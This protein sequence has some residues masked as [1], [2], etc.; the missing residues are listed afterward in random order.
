MLNSVN[1]MG[2]LVADPEL[3]QTQTGTPVCSFRIAVDRN[4]SNANNQRET[5]FI[6][7]VA[8][9]KTAEFVTQYFGKGAMIIVQGSIQTRNYEDKNGNKRTAVEVVASNVLF[10][11][12]KAAAQANSAPQ[13]AP[14]PAQQQ[15]G[16]Q[17]YGQPQSPPQPAPAPYGAPQQQYAALPQQGY[18]QP[19]AY[20]VQ[21]QYAPPPVQQ[22]PPPQGAP[23]PYAPPTQP[24]AGYA[25]TN[26]PSYDEFGDSGDLPF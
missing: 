3:R 9:R 22:A 16:Q 5:D 6:D 1:L 24:P 2:R 12:T 21:A 18:A 25:G 20:P 4:F 15:Y 26:A 10:G 8:W 23:A 14:Q 11:E 7:I 17:P 13:S 19:P